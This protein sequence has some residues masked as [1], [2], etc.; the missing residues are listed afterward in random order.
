MRRRSSDSPRWRPR[1]RAGKYLRTLRRGAP[2]CFAPLSWRWLALPIASAPLVNL[3][4]F[5]LRCSSARARHSCARRYAHDRA[6]MNRIAVDGKLEAG[7]G[8]GFPT[9]TAALAR[10]QELQAG[11]ACTLQSAR[12]IVALG[13][14]LPLARLYSLRRTNPDHA[15]RITCVHK[16]TSIAE[17]FEQ[18]SIDDVAKDI[19]V[20]AEL[21]K[22][23]FVGTSI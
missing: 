18:H 9:S 13:E 21:T 7:R 22:T 5:C 3:R 10:R 1:F 16:I 17:Q 23:V 2:S 6:F 20:V 12:S 8:P 15:C 4:A 11:D 19:G 14:G